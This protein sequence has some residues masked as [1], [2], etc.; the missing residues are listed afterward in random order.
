M[1]ECGM[2]EEKVKIHRVECR[3]EGQRL[4]SMP[5]SFD[6]TERMYQ[7]TSGSGSPSAE[8]QSNC[9]VITLRAI[10]LDLAVVLPAN[11]LKADTARGSRS[12]T[13]AFIIIVVV[14]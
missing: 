14:K 12:R 8:R 9:D 13:A 3:V 1:R 7:R 4:D 11:G 2:K 6:A 10:V 5:S